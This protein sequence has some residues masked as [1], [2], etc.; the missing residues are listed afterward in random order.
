MPRAKKHH[1]QAVSGK[2][3]VS[4]QVAAISYSSRSIKAGREWLSIATMLLL[5]T[6][7]Q[8]GPHAWTRAARAPLRSFLGIEETS[9]SWK[10]DDKTAAEG[11]KIKRE[12]KQRAKSIVKE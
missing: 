2:S 11:I 1:E 10:T 6:S 9:V 4:R 12:K 7:R 8:A 5:V 3:K